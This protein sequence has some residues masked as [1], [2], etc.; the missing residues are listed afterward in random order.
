MDKQLRGPTMATAQPSSEHPNSNLVPRISNPWNEWIYMEANWRSSVHGSHAFIDLTINFNEEWFDLT[1]GRLKL[2]FS[3]GDLRIA[4]T[5][6]TVP[7]SARNPKTPLAIEIPVER[8]VTSSEKTTEEGEGKAKVGLEGAKLSLG[9]EASSKSGEEIQRQSKNKF[10][11]S[12]WQVTS[13]GSPELPIWS[14]RVNNDEPI[15]L[16][17]LVSYELAKAT[18]AKRPCTLSANF[19][20][21]R[22]DVKVTQVEGLWPGNWI[23]NKEKLGFLIVRRW[24]WKHFQPAVSSVEAHYV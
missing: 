15:L 12:K 19:V 9:V 22:S 17:N 13:K 5:E 6:C 18:I 4:L 8:E 10:L 16:G 20:V 7:L 23:R 24:L 21:A 2:G 1:L 11:L 14:F 3:G